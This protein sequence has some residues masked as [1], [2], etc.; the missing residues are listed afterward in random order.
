[1]PTTTLWKPSR[2]ISDSCLD[3]S[4]SDTAVASTAASALSDHMRTSRNAPTVRKHD[5]SLVENHAN[6]SPTYLSSLGCEPC[7]WIL[8]TLKRCAIDQNMSKSPASS[9]TSLMAAIITPYWIPSSL[10]TQLSPSTFSPIHATLP[11]VFRQTVFLHSSGVVRP[12]GR[13]SFSIIIFLQ[14]SVFRR[15]TAYTL[16][17][18]QVW[19]NP[20]IGIP[21]AGR[22]FR[23]LSN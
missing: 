8:R 18:F 9:R 22:S 3:S 1:M 16:G 19:R 11:L 21:F 14:K 6:V 2:N 23:N 10:L 7:L 20:G 12:A 4:P 13:W 5:T 15:N 17:Q